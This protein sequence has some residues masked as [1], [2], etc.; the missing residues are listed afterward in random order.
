L[1]VIP[2]DYVL[3][4]L[5]PFLADKMVWVAVFGW[6]LNGANHFFGLGLDS[7]MLNTLDASLSAATVA[8]LSHVKWIGGNP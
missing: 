8:H 3:S 5:A 6:A 2:V 4:F 7:A 1:E